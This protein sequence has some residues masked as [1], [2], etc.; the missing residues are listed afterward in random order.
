MKRRNFIREMV[1]LSAAPLLVLPRKSL[2]QLNPAFVGASRKVAAG[3]TCPASPSS[4]NDGA[5]WTRT[6]GGANLY[7]GQFRWHDGGTP[8][9]ICRLDFEIG[10]NG[11]GHDF[12][13]EIHAVSGVYDLDVT[14]LATS[15]VV[16][17]ANWG[18][19]TWVRF[20]FASPYT[21]TASAEYCLVVRP[22]TAWD[23]A[24][25]LYG[26]NTAL[27]GYSDTA[28][29]AGAANNASGNDASIR[30]YWQ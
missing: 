11:T 1:L 18:A 16:T 29:S 27:T 4:E 24:M 13:A 15:D 25:A 30:I 12:R 20:D 26:D 17:G 14:S 7:A 21:T 8:R 10:E 28:S 3:A 19:G 22:V 6:W 5:T 23:N 9:T 2:A